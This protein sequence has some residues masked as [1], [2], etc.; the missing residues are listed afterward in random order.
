MP[1]RERREIVVVTNRSFAGGKRDMANQTR[2]SVVF[3]VGATGSEKKL[4]ATRPGSLPLKYRAQTTCIAAYRPRKAS[5]NTS[6][7]ET[8]IF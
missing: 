1:R 5:G 6:C 2:L 7:Y 3:D 4:E 8:A